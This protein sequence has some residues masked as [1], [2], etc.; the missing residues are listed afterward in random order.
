MA[1][2]DIKNLREAIE[3]AE[4]YKEQYECKYKEWEKICEDETKYFRE[5]NEFMLECT[6][7]RMDKMLLEQQLKVL[8]VPVV[9][10]RKNKYYAKMEI[11][12]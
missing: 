1:I 3:I 9:A 12:L 6:Q 4:L 5:R 8:G 7:L 2:K 10:G 11:L